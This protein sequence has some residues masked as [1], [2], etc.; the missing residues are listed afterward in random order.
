MA[1]RVRAGRG[2]GCVGPCLVKDALLEGV[3][4]VRGKD[5]QERL[6][7]DDGFS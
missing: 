5:E 4:L 2:M 7:E 3:E 1:D 6:Q